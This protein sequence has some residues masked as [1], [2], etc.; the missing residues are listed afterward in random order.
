MQAVLFLLDT[1]VG[2]FCSLFML[3]FLMQAMRVSFSG[4]LAISSLP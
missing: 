4:Q 1:I 2:F 3:R